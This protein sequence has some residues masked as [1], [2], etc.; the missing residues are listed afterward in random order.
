MNLALVFVNWEHRLIKMHVWIKMC[1]FL[2]HF[3]GAVVS[4]IQFEKALV[5]GSSSYRRC[6]LKFTREKKYL[7]TFKEQE[8]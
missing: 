6:I 5:S 4:L 8:C 2:F 7:K 1:S 3:F